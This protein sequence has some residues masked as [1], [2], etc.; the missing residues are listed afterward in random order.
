M[1]FRILLYIVSLFRK[2][3]KMTNWYKKSQSNLMTNP[4]IRD[5]KFDWNKTLN[6]E[7]GWN[8]FSQIYGTPWKNVVE[9]DAGNPTEEEKYKIIEKGLYNKE[10]SPETIKYLKKSIE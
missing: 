2:K 9:M 1:F 3:E 8:R 6:K 4:F 10:I 5:I 7:R